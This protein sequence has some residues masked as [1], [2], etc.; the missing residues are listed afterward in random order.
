MQPS[1]SHAVTSNELLQG[2]TLVCNLANPEQY[3]DEACDD[4]DVYADRARGHSPAPVCM[5]EQ[6][7]Y[8][9]GT[10]HLVTM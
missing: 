5:H 4:D 6:R 3:I 1:C 9:Q 8:W 7:M 10:K 2:T